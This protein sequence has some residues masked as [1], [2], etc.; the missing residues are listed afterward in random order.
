MTIGQAVSRCFSKY[1]TCSGRASRSEYWYWCLFVLVAGLC[2]RVADGLI[3][4][5]MET[6]PIHA[7]VTLVTFLPG[8]A[9]SVRRLHDVNRSGWWLVIALTGIGMIFPLLY[10]FVQP[11]RYLTPNCRF[12]NYLFLILWSF[13]SYTCMNFKFCVFQPSF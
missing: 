3:L 13:V 12:T 6:Q 9:V 2:A 5:D 11:I 10:W 8:L 4:N 1:A 7:I